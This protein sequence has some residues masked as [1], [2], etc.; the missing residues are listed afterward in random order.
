MY[1]SDQQEDGTLLHFITKNKLIIYAYSI[2]NVQCP[3]P[4]R[5]TTVAQLSI[6]LRAS[7]RLDSSLTFSNLL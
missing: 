6:D 4:D 1:S 7:S 3:F 2:F 5:Y